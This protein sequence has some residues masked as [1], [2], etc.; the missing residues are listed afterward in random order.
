MY[1]LW[2]QVQNCFIQVTGTSITFIPAP[3]LL[4]ISKSSNISGCETDDSNTFTGIANQLILPLYNS[5][6]KSMSD[7]WKLELINYPRLVKLSHSLQDNATHY[8][9]Y[10][11]FKLL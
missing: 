8:N 6:A 3:C 10:L 9:N 7:T 11:I 1:N 4:D 5:Y 2:A